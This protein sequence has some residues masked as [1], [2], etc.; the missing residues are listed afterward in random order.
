M[1]T[2]VGIFFRFL[3]AALA[4][5]R[6]AF[7]LARERGPWNVFGRLRNAAAHV[8]IGELL[9]CVKC[10]GLWTAVPFAVFVHGSGWELLVTWLALAGVTALIDEWTRPPF[11]WHEN[12]ENSH[13]SHEA[14]H[15][16]DT[17]MNQRDRKSM[18]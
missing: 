8:G 12:N 2:E 7:L 6:L 3:I 16:D 17:V 9:K 18:K 4:A 5:W 1:T 14:S 15:R 11:E 10:V 13:A